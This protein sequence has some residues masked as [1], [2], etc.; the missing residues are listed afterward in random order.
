MHRESLAAIRTIT[1]PYSHIPFLRVP[2]GEFLASRAAHETACSTQRSRHCSQLEESAI[3]LPIVHWRKSSM[4]V[5]RQ[6]GSQTSRRGL[7]RV[8]TSSLV[9]NIASSEATMAQQQGDL[10]F[11]EKQKVLA[12]GNAPVVPGWCSDLLENRGTP[13]TAKRMGSIWLASR[14]AGRVSTIDVVWR[15]AERLCCRYKNWTRRKPT[16]QPMLTHNNV[17]TVG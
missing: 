12:G 13:R 17:V 11:N 4:R 2:R 15:H 8:R 6:K 7:Q 16:C 14:V 5:P 3:L 10:L 9:Q 1:A